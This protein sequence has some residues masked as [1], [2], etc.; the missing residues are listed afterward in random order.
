MHQID[1]QYSFPAPR[2]FLDFE[3]RTIIKEVMSIFVL[4][5]KMVGWAFEQNFQN[6]RYI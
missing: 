3:N 4:E 6:V 1:L 2:T 5:P